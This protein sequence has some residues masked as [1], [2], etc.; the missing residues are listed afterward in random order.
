MRR[1]S[2]ASFA[3]L[4]VEFGKP[5]LAKLVYSSIKPDELVEVKGIKAFSEIKEDAIVFRVK[6]KRGVMSL[7]YTLYEY[8][9]YLKLIQEAVLILEEAKCP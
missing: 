4:K 1:N 6:C 2:S 5:S 3:M 8:L 7:A 9:Q